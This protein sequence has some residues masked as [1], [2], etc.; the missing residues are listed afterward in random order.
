MTDEEIYRKFR[1][2]L[3]NPGARSMAIGGAFLSLA[4]DATAAQAN[5]AGLAYLNRWEFFAE[6][7]AI[8]NGVR[9]EVQNE[10]LP[11]DVTSLI[12]SVFDLDDTVSP[13]FV[14]GVIP[15]DT[16]FRWTLGFSR[17]EL[18]RL[19]TS[20]ISSF[21]FTSSS[22]PGL[23]LVQGEGDIDV[24]V[25]NWN[26][27]AGFR[28][29]DSLALGATLTL[30][31]MTASS[32]V[33]NFVVD[34]EGVISGEEIL[35]PALDVRTNTDASDSDFVFNVGLIYQRPVWGLGAVF[36]KGPDFTVDEEILLTLEDD[37]PSTGLDVFGVRDVIGTP[38]GNRFALPDSW[39]VG[40]YWR[41]GDR[42]TLSL[43]IQRILYSSL[44][45]DFVAGL[46]VLTDF[47]AVFAADDG[48]DIRFG[49]EHILAS[50]R[51]PR[52]AIR[53]GGYLEADSTIRAVDTGTNSLASEDVFEGDG[54]Q[55]HGTFGLGI[56][57]RRFKVDLAADLS[58]NRREYV[59]SF[60]LQAK[61]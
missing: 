47:D 11:G 51:R 39:G 26:V 22:Q 44:E 58:E 2:N 43:D 6:L 7:R 24:E 38:F 32:S 27:S 8:D 54:D 42:W 50:R 41:P 19:N 1:F 49:V 5:P 23:F 9:A 57:M 40:G 15:F 13:S 46:N 34:T 35:E 3:V 56:L 59:V 25:V 37:A 16:G 31:E 36:R 61:R 29:T 28:I 18:L 55:I 17:Q 45:S 14:A 52:L 21:S 4:D 33:V 53:F 20:T 48:T 12:G 30:S 60:I 10:D